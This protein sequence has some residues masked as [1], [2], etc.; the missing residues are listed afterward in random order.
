MFNTFCY[1]LNF[2]HPRIPAA[3]R[4]LAYTTLPTQAW[5]YGN[6]PQAGYRG[7][8][9]VRGLGVVAFIAEDGALTFVW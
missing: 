5:T 9:N 2:I 3:L 7:G 6:G 4:W 1:Y 8:V